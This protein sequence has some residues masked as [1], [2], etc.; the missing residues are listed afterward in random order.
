MPDGDAVAPPELAAD[1]PVAFLAEPVEV[2]LG[3]PLRPDPHGAARHG[4][5]RG[6]G[7]FG[8]AD[9]PLVG[10]V[11]LDRRLRAVGVG[12]LDE[13]VLH[14]Q[15]LARGLEVGHDLRPRP[16]DREAHVG[17]GLGVEPAVGLEDVD[18]QQPLPQAHVVVVGIVG[19]GDLHAAGAHL[20]LGPLVGHQRDRPAEQGQPDLPAV[21]RHRRELFEAGQQVAAAGGEVV[22]GRVYLGDV[23]GGRGG[24]LLPQ[25]PFGLV[26][27]GGGLRVHGHGRV[28]QERLRPGRRHGQARR[29]AGPGIDHV[30]ADVPEVALHRLVE[31]LVVADGRLQERVPVDQ[32]LAAPHETLA[33][34]PQEGLA[35][36]PRAAVVEREPHAVPVAAGAE[37]A[38]LPEDPLLILL[39]PGP[40]PRDEPL[41]AEIVAGELF[42]LEQPPLHDRLRGDAGVIGAGH[43]EREESLHPPGADEHV[44]QR[45]VEGV[46]EVEGAGHVGGRDDDREDPA[47]GGRLGMPEAAGVPEGQAPGLGGPV[48]VVLR[49]FVHGRPRKRRD[50]SRKRRSAASGPV[51]ERGPLR[52]GQKPKATPRAGRP[53]RAYT[54]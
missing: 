38:E 17:S 39:L 1:R 34:Q 13:P 33:E 53:G 32:P 20:G 44:L 45:V 26:E 30:V 54:F 7:E 23:P 51:G 40:D 15:E 10:E 24:P 2:A 43:P 4:V 12:Q 18:H 48:V 5:E 46:A 47:A 3:I 50:C 31:D 11:G 27:R 22:E 9:E 37:V 28:A 29:L 21:P 19:G 25:G 16:R 14:L 36:S 52:S 8:H 42:L 41:A 35:D 49:Q 6:L